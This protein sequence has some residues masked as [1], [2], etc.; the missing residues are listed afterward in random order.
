MIFL[1]LVSHIIYGLLE[2]QPFT[3]QIASGSFGKGT[4]ASGRALYPTN[5]DTHT[6]WPR[7]KKGP[8]LLADA[9]HG[10]AEETAAWKLS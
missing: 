7:Y 8:A 2:D 5:A 4:K 9:I 1:W 3:L 6:A 10:W